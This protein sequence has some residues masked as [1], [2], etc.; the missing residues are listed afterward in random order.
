MHDVLYADEGQ[1]L[2]SAGSV[3]G[4]YLCLYIVRQDFGS[5]VAKRSVLLAH[6]E[7]RQVQ[8]VP[9]P[10]PNQLAC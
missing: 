1:I 7:G 9:S 3:A 6:K 8:F 4:I 10:L 2:T 5:V